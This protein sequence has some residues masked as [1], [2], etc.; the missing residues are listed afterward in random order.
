MIVHLEIVSFIVSS[1]VS[2]KTTTIS[3]DVYGSS[4][5]IVQTS[6]VVT[7]TLFFNLLRK[8]RTWKMNLI[9]RGFWLCICLSIYQKNLNTLAWRWRTWIK[10]F[11][12][13]SPRILLLQDINK[14]S[15][16]KFLNFIV[17]ASLSSHFSCKFFHTLW[18]RNKKTR[19]GTFEKII[20]TQTWSLILQF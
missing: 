13:C 3:T 5:S 10:W 7:R 18:E 15:S 19:M 1:R 9:L 4:G 20:M 11:P 2:I 17:R 6:S 12:Y 14:S 16:F 8:N